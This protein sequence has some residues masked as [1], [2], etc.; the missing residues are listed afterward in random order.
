M[1]SLISWGILGIASAILLIIYWRGRNAVWGGLTLGI[2]IGFIVA[3]VFMFRENGFNLLTVGKGAIA[4]TILGY[5]AE[6]LGK[7]SD[8]LKKIK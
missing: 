5:L 3:I 4:G 1:T 7:V 8:L 6:L 2:I